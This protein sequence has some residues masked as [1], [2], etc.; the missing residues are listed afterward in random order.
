MFE[1]GIGIKDIRAALEN[2]ESIENYA[3]STSYPARLVLTWRGRRPL[4]LV[5]ADN[6]ADDEVIVITGYRPDPTRWTEDFKWRRDEVPD[7]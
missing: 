1:R 6:L 7:V 4:H 2:G 3:D 5:A